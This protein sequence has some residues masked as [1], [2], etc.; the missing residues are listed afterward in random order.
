MIQMC[1]IPAL[2]PSSEGDG[3]LAK[4]EHLER[5][6]KNMDLPFE[7]VDAPDDRVSS[8][9]RPNL[10]VRVPGKLKKTVWIVS[11]TDIVPPGDLSGWRHDPFE[12]TIE[13][14]R[15]IGRGVEDNGQSVIAS[16]Y[17]LWAVR[18]VVSEPELSCGL[19]LVADEET[20]SEY[21]ISY[22]I[23]QGTF[24]KGDLIV[25][26]DRFS[27]DGSEIEITEKNILWIRIIVEG[28]QTHASTPERG[29]NAHRA[30]AHLITWI[31]EHLHKVF[32]A[33]DVRFKPAISTFEPTKKEAN[34][35]NV[36]TIPGKD[37]FFI[38]C[39]ILPKY[40]TR[41]V[42]EEIMKM[43]N[44]AEKE[45]SVKVAIEK[46]QDESSPETAEDAEI[47]VRTGSAIRDV[48]GVEPR[49]VGV[50][51]GT[52]AAHFRKAGFAAVVCGTGDETAHDVNEYAVIDNLVKDAKIYAALFLG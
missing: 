44:R 9:V 4:V 37:V 18:K 33:E 47:V 24:D 21:G 30:G 13:G 28:K 26:P 35:P 39:R 42:F 15:I 16:I 48:L 22:L 8:G 43:A 17:A 10:L 3:E 23:R 2:D 14:G 34:V 29:I 1:R 32:D 7:R 40:A 19:A 27:A 50:G 49:I 6:L 51:G 46:V 41:E 52:C 45:F 12:P 11:H 25:V 36:N 31:D 38:D 5:Q 20:G